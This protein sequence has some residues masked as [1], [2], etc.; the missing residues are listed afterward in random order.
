MMIPV[1]VNLGG[2]PSRPLPPQLVQFGTDEVVLVELQGS[3]EVEGNLNGQ[4]VG[5]LTVDGEKVSS[6]LFAVAS[7]WSTPRRK[8]QPSALDTTY[9]RGSSSTSPNHLL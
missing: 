6:C 3:L 1:H 5:K 4:Y 7:V 9:S 2:Y 8:S